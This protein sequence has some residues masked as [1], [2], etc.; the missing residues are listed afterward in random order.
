MSEQP[1]G[2]PKCLSNDTMHDSADP[3]AVSLARQA[4]WTE[5]DV[6]QIFK[7]HADHLYRQGHFDQAMEQYIKTIGSVQ[8]S[9]VIRKVCEHCIGVVLFG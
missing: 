5:Q 9:H 8:P 2:P 7:K 4:G 1:A 6:A 3:Q